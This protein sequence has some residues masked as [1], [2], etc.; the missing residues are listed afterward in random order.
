MLEG[1]IED[2]ATKPEKMLDLIYTQLT[3]A[4]WILG[5]AGNKRF[6]RQP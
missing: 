6:Q 2:L 3:R 1:A 5:I 4:A